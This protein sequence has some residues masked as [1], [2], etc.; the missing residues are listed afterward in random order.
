[1]ATTPSGLSS[2]DVVAAW[3]TITTENP[4]DNIN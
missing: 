4:V 2:Q 1:M 3:Q